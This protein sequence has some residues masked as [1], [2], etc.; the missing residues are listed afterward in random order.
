MVICLERGADLHMAQLMQ[1]PLTVS[2]FSK[3]IF[4]LSFWYWLTCVVPDKGPLKGCVWGDI[5]PCFVRHRFAIFFSELGRC[6][7]QLESQRRQLAQSEQTCAELR[8]HDA[9]TREAVAAKDAQIAVLRTRLDE[10]DRELATKSKQL[11]DLGS[12]QDR[13]VP[14]IDDAY[15]QCSMLCPDKNSPVVSART[16]SNF[17]NFGDIGNSWYKCSFINFQRRI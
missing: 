17:G 9:D 15:C 13:Y 14:M 10:G 16:L 4:V 5:K 3:T 12:S 1:L 8:R 6:Q 11:A 7:R 2:C